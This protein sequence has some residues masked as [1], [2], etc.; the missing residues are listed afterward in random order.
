MMQVCHSGH[1]ITASMNAFPE[2]VK[3]FCPDCGEATLSACSSCSRNIRGFDWDGHGIRGPATPKFCE[4]CG[5]PFPW[6][7]A[8]RAA[9]LDLIDDADEVPE[10]DKLRL[11]EALR[12]VQTDGPRTAVGV[13][14]IKKLIQQG[15]LTVGSS[16]YKI[17]ID[18]MSDAAKK[19]FED[20]L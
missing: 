1:Q 7:V 10:A 3:A 15:S 18:V 5:Q 13:S 9:A 16:L 8:Q 12:D 4:G 14:R 2:E 17:F 19:H 11:R 20:K 6:T